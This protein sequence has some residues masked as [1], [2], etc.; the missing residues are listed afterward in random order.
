MHSLAN[1]EP[2]AFLKTLND[3]INFIFDRGMFLASITL[4]S[5]G[6]RIFNM[7]DPS[8]P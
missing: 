1:M 2:K 6:C 7:S 4:Y 8:L 5:E 3:I